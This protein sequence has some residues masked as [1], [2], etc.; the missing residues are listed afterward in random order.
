MEASPASA[1]CSVRKIWTGWV[2]AEEP[3]EDDLEWVLGEGGLHVFDV[4]DV[5]QS[6]DVVEE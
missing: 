1:K 2:E 4:V 3:V 5:G 6:G